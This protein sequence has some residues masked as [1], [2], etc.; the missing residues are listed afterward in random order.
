M[1]RVVHAHYNSGDMRVSTHVIAIA[2]VLFVS[3][4]SGSEPAPSLTSAAS[5]ERMPDTVAQPSPPTQTPLPT[6]APTVAVRPA[7][8]EC[9]APANP[10]LP[11]TPI[12]EQM[13]NA[14]LSY[15]N[16]GASL[17]QLNAALNAWNATMIQPAT[18][19]V[20]GGATSARLL[21][22]DDAQIIV[23]FSLAQDNAATRAGDVLIAACDKGQYRAVYLAS[24]EPAF[25]AQ[26]PNPRLHSVIDV[27]GDGI[28]DVSFASGECGSGTCIDSLT[29][30]AHLPA[31]DA[32]G[33]TN[34]SQ[35]IAGVPNA[36]FSFTPNGAGQSLTIVHGTF[37]DVNAGPQRSSSETWAFNGATMGQIGATREPALYRIHALHDADD[38]FRRKDFAGASG[39]YN[40][41]L[42]DA[43][44]QAWDGPGALQEEQSALGAFAQFR[45]AQIALAQGNSAGAK[46]A[47]ASLASM[48]ANAESQPYAAMAKTVGDALTDSNDA[49]VACNTAVAFAEKNPK[50]YEQL[51]SATFGFANPD[52]QPADMCIQ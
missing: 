2:L 47:L 22:K 28:G 52:Y 39:L 38:A 1:Q 4:C 50:T 24:Q 26:L 30:I 36:T 37:D 21:P 3:A 44:L 11:Q 18:N 19:A 12:A 13:P 51:G 34:I 45:L 33:L 25:S 29:I 49:V 23:V 10:P 27:T 7:N 6:T 42:S 15:L 43:S 8:S 14:V 32:F 48:P 20:I 31:Q 5:T 9:P 35:D 40:R 16:A 41:V 17:D 46:S